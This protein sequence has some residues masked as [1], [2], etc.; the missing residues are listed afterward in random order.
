MRRK[1][2]RGDPKIAVAYLRVSTEDQSLGPEAQSA[3][4][5]TWAQREGIRIARWCSDQGVSGA[6]EPEQRPAF[7]EAMGALRE[8]NAGV[9]VVAKRDRL[10][11]DVMAARTIAILAEKRG[12]WSVQPMA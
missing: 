11:R 7:M 6:M 9:L 2:V 4:I 3:A 10:A 1:P 8:H 12:P 5:V